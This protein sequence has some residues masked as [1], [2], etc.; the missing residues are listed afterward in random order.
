M[1]EILCEILYLC[2]LLEKVKSVW[3]LY[4][5]SSLIEHDHA[6]VVVKAK[7]KSVLTFRLRIPRIILE[8]ERTS[9]CYSA[10]E[11]PY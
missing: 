3:P 8:N 5:V 1:L 6:R 4:V 2:V 10:V 11:I 9:K 7:K